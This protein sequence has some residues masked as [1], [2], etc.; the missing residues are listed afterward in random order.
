MEWWVCIYL[1]QGYSV[2]VSQAAL[3]FVSAHSLYV[4]SEFKGLSEHRF[5]LKSRGDKKKRGWKCVA[6]SLRLS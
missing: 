4:A 6:F 2:F 1:Q 3:N 5:E